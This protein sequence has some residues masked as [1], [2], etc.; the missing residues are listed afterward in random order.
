MN[1]NYNET[2]P[3]EAT[4]AGTRFT[5]GLEKARFTTLKRYNVDTLALF[6][7]VLNSISLYLHRVLQEARWAG[8]KMRNPGTRRLMRE[9]SDYNRDPHEDMEIFPSEN[10]YVNI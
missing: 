1:T 7:C 4:N 5:E 10:E 6:L 2:D 3:Y 9:I 8:I